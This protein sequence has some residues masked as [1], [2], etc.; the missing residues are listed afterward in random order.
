MTEFE[1]KLYTTIA[2]IDKK[3]QTPFGT[4]RYIS[5]YKIWTFKH[6]WNKT[7]FLVNRYFGAENCTFPPL[8]TS[9]QRNIQHYGQFY[10]GQIYMVTQ[11]TVRKCRVIW[12]V[13]G[14]GYGW[15]RTSKRDPDP[16][17]NKIHPFI[18]IHK[19]QYSQYIK[20]YYNFGQ[21]TLIF[22]FLPD[23]PWICFFFKNRSGSEYDWIQ[24]HAPVFLI[25]LFL[26][27]AINTSLNG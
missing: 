10:L 14:Y 24:I 26:F 3:E 15:I 4:K 16:G 9:I 5:S 18:I 2:Y 21:Y 25:R 8:Q 12:S 22:F 6:L 1:T 23:P 20:L 7:F 11:K 13:M 17:L 27:N 19:S